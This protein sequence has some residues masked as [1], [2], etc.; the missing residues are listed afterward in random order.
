MRWR[1][2]FWPAF[3]AIFLQVLLCLVTAG[4]YLPAAYVK[5]Y[6]YFVQR[7]ELEREGQPYGKLGFDGKAGQGFLRIWGQA[8]LTLITVG[9]Y[10][11]WAMAKIGRWFAGHTT[12]DTPSA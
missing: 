3:G 7:T 9:F 5:L 2:R 1:T 8:L 10:Y 11:P 12:L 4:I 6:R